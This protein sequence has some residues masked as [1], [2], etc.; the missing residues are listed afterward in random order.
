GQI[1]PAA[2]HD[3]DEGAYD[4]QRPWGEDYQ[5]PQQRGEQ[6]DQDQVDQA[7][8]HE[9]GLGA[10][11]HASAQ[12]AR[13]STCTATH[14]GTHGA[15]GGRTQ[16]HAVRGGAAPRRIQASWQPRSSKTCVPRWPSSRRSPTTWPPTRRQ[17]GA[18]SVTG[19]ATSSSF[20]SMAIVL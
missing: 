17:C 10:A 15:K 1:E 3:H 11:R 6:D 13:S 19:T 4:G 2:S 16:A 9:H 14:G 8:G 20:Q 5:G 7:D 18:T 12:G